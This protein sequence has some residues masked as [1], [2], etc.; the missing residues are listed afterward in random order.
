MKLLRA[1][2]PATI[3]IRTDVRSESG[4]IFAD[5]TQ[6]Q[7][8]LMNLCMNGA[9]AMQEKGGVL[10]VEISDFTVSESDGNPHGIKPGLYMRLTVRDTG[11]G[12]S[13]DII[14]KIFD[15]FFTTKKHREPAR[16]LHFGRE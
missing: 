14:D 12:I 1:S 16:W 11:T 10:H 9:Y 2:I 8:V 15:P 13:S 6:M 5:P 4:L 7:Q 3:S